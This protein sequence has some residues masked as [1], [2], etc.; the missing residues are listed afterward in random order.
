MAIKR[1]K[2]L[3]MLIL[4]GFIVTNALATSYINTFVVSKTSVAQNKLLTVFTV[5]LLNNGFTSA[6]LNI[7]WNN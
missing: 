6:R 5:N 1:I 4:N 7:N 2:A 3:D